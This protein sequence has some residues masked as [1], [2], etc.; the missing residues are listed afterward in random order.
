MSSCEQG[1]MATLQPMGR[2][3]STSLNLCQILSQTDTLYIDLSLAGHKLWYSLSC[4]N[5]NGPF[6]AHEPTQLWKTNGYDIL[7]NSSG[8]STF[9]LSVLVILEATSLK[10]LRRDQLR[11]CVISSH[12]TFL[13]QQ[14]AVARL[15][16]LLY[17]PRSCMIR[18]ELCPI[19]N[20]VPYHSM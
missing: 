2:D 8:T 12:P 13:F 15:T 5:W 18:K 10:N 16:F 11:S 9:L 1:V 4:L 6:L 14:T 7:N 3:H 17:R 19:K 20:K